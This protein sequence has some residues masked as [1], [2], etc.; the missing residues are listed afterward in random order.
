[1]SETEEK[2]HG[3]EYVRISF[4]GLVAGSEDA[5]K[6]LL[7]SCQ[8]HSFAYLDLGTMASV[9]EDAIRYTFPT[10]LDQPGSCDSLEQCRGVLIRDVEEKL[11]VHFQK[12]R[13][14][15]S[16][17]E[18]QTD[19]VLDLA[20]QCWEAME[21]VA[22]TCLSSLT[23]SLGLGSAQDILAKWGD[24][25]L[26]PEGSLGN[27]I[28]DIFKYHNDGTKL[29]NLGAHF[30]PGFVTVLKDNGVAGLQAWDKDTGHLTDLA[31]GK[32][33]AVVILNKGL[34]TLSSGRLPACLHQVS[35]APST[36]MSMVFETRPNPDK[37][38]AET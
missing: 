20:G 10:F 26:L 17:G 6:V 18:G 12:T 33:E 23:E 28:L 5:R 37:F 2:K 24:E 36:R 29:S 1:M 22:L 31:I 25:S 15:W 8:T 19:A 34:E 38:Y 13:E 9:L 32:G 21:S 4:P 7:Q 16:T 11:Q 30:D 27:S 35:A 14:T 3:S